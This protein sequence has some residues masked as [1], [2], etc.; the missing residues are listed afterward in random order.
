MH[1]PF[2]F[3][4]EEKGATTGT[5]QLDMLMRL[6]DFV[7]DR[8]AEIDKLQGDVEDLKNDTPKTP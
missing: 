3:T 1:N 8:L 6:V 5:E 2:E 4:D 7:N